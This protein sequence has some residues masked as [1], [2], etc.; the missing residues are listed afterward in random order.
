MAIIKVYKGNIRGE[1][2]LIATDKIG[3]KEDIHTLINVTKYECRR[4]LFAKNVSNGEM[5]IAVGELNKL[6]VRRGSQWK[7]VDESYQRLYQ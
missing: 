6:L 4:K 2:Y 7:V 1:T 5:R 3:N